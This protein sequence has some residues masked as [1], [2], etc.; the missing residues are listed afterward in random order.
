VT[1]GVLVQATCDTHLFGSRGGYRTVA[2]SSGVSAQERAEL[3]IFGF[4][5]LSDRR[6]QQALLARAS[7]FGRRL[8]SGRFAVTRILPGPDDD[9]GRPTLELRTVLLDRASYGAIAASGIALLIDTGAVWSAAA[10][11]EGRSMY[12]F[13]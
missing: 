1:K 3:E 11:A 13:P 9:G 7:A 12:G 4:G 5:Q 2:S 6:G 10:F 8:S